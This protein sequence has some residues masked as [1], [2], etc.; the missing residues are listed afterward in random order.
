MWLQPILFLATGLERAPGLDHLE[1]AQ[2]PSRQACDRADAGRPERPRA[3]G[4]PPPRRA[5]VPVTAEQRR[6]LC[7]LLVEVLIEIRW[8]A[9]H[10]ESEQ[11]GDLADAVHNL[12][13]VM[14]EPTFS[15][16]WCRDYLQ[17]YQEKYPQRGDFT[18][19]VGMVERI[20]KGYVDS[21][22]KLT[23]SSP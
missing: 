3:A 1:Q 22:L 8:R 2:R 4:P 20:S 7:Q 6:E 23:P 15:W 9:W 19:Y 21:P 13:L 17:H 10:G 5:K 12:P 11:V 18:D 14:Y 16:S